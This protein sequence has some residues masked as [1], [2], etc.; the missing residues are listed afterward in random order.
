MSVSAPSFSKKG[1]KGKSIYFIFHQSSRLGYMRKI[2]FIIMMGLS[3]G[4]L[5]FSCSKE[6]EAPVQTIDVSLNVNQ[7]YTYALGNFGDE[8]GAIIST[9]AM[10]FSQSHLERVAATGAMLY[11]YLPAINFAGTDEVTIKSMRGTDGGGGPY[12][13]IVYTKIRFVI[14]P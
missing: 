11:H 14:H 1:Y 7:T 13:N 5:L 2:F 4:C 6:E 10:H 8:E 9:E 12:K 3:L